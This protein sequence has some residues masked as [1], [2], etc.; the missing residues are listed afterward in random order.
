MPVAEKVGHDRRDNTVYER[1]ADGAEIVRPKTK[2]ILSRRAN[3]DII[4]EIAVREKEIDDDLPKIG[5]AYRE[6]Q[7]TGRVGEESLP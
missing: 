6:F 1:D 5:A 4:T 7:R 3:R 2:S